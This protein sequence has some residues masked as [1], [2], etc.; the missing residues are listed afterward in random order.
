MLQASLLADEKR[1]LN[2]R[3]DSLHR[4]ILGLTS[5]LN[6]ER[7]GTANASLDAASLRVALTG[8]RNE[9]LGAKTE[10]S[11]LMAA[12]RAPALGGGYGS[13]GGMQTGMTS[14]A[15]G[16]A[17]TAGS[18]G[19]MAAAAAA[20]AM[21][22]MAGADAAA[23]AAGYGGM[24][25]RG[26]EADAAAAAA[27]P[28]NV[29]PASTSGSGAGK[30]V[31][32]QRLGPTGGGTFRLSGAGGGIGSSGG[33]SGA[34]SASAAAAAAAAAAA[35]NGGV[36]ALMQVGPG[37][38]VVG[39]RKPNEPGT[40]AADAVGHN[41]S[42]EGGNAGGEHLEASEAGLA[43]D[44]DDSGSEQQDASGDAS[45]GV[46]T[47]RPG[48]NGRKQ[49]AIGSA[50]AP[51]CEA[52]GAEGADDGKKDAHMS[53]PGAAAAAAA[54]LAAAAACSPLAGGPGAV[55]RQRMSDE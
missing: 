32:G 33:G 12:M 6:A 38:L 55:K 26:G 46:G 37:T 34:G 45:R 9:L 21:M 43:G 44:E 13:L 28:V 39:P 10:M 42:M 23:A 3:V 40:A 51:S 2:L 50:R 5:Q 7:A 30:K 8:I 54:G 47:P 24:T 4:D 49:G 48:G 15:F 25:Y 20:A 17:P 22:G 29:M 36:G 1:A 35:N 27:M 16:A 11:G 18:G 14:A 19:G 52:G 31:F 53:E 41:G